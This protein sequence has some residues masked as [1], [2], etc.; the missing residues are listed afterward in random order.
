MLHPRIIVF[1][2]TLTTASSRDIGIAASRPDAFAESVHLCVPNIN[3]WDYL[4]RP[5]NSDFG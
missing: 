3:R 4:T 5:V 1:A 2:E